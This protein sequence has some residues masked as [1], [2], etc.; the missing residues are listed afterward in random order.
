MRILSS[1]YSSFLSIISKL[2]WLFELF[3][4]LRLLLKFLGA[5]S[6]TLVVSLVYERSDV[7]IAPF[8]FIFRDIYWKGHLVEMSVISA[9]VGYAIAAFIVF[10]ILR[11]F[12]RD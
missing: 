11:L 4:F 1:V 6:Q 2:F 3:L 7:V 12:S 8:S 10:K 9:I 5:N